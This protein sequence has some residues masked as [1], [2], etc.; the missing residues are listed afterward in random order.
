MPDL[1][2]L[3]ALGETVQPPPLDAL[4]AVSRTRRRQDVTAAVAACCTVAL[5]AAGAVV[6]GFDGASDSDPEPAPPPPTPSRAATTPG[7]LETIRPDGVLVLAPGEAPGAVSLDGGRYAVHL[8]GSTLAEIDVP[9]GWQVQYGHYLQPNPSASQS[10][11][12]FI[13]GSTGERTFVPADPCRDQSFTEAEPT[14][15]DLA[16]DLAA[17]PFLET[18]KQARTSVGGVEARLVELRIPADADLLACQQ[19]RVVLYRSGRTASGV[20]TAGPEGAVIRL[21]VLEVHGTRYAIHAQWAETARDLA[22]LTGMVRSITF[23]RD[24]PSDGK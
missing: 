22:V 21:W 23:T 7:Y 11:M 2:Q 9:D 20:W 13:T 5:I 1:N 4:R 3:R 15:D 16:T 24:G 12:V 19:N 8:S 18:T 14:V 17:L 6:V 10:G